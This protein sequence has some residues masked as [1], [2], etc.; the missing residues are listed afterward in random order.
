MA[1]RRMRRR[2]FARV[3]PR[4][5]YRRRRSGSS[6]LS[7]TKLMTGGAIYGA[8]RPY[9]SDKVG[10]LLPGVLGQFG[11][12]VIMG[13]IAL[14]ARKKLK[15]VGRDIATSALAVESAR[16]GESLTQQATARNQ[17]T[18]FV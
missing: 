5:S 7:N 9:V 13:A 8:I 4:S 12:E 18:Q 6:G 1:R 14:F 10:G 11:D 16:L 2:S 17:I 15:G 3:A